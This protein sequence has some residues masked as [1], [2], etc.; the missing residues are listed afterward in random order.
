MKV[1]LLFLLSLASVNAITTERDCPPKGCRDDAK[2]RITNNSTFENL[3][4]KDYAGGTFA[5]GKRDLNSNNSGTPDKLQKKDYAGGTFAL[6]K[7][8]LNSNGSTSDKLQ[9]KD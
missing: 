2:R 7:R 6:G 9:K 1:L 5:L 4:K 3:Q 8:D